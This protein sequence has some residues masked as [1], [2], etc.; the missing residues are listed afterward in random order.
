[1]YKRNK[2]NLSEYKLVRW[3]IMTLINMI[4][5]T[6]RKIRFIGDIHSMEL[7]QCCPSFKLTL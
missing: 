3:P 7:G 5:Y 4:S 6:N 1:M 2:G